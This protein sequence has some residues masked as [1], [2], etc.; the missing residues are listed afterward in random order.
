VTRTSILEGALE[1]FATA[2]FDGVSVRE[3]T[4]RLGVSHNL[5]HHYFGSKQ[6]LW[7]AVLDYALGEQIGEVAERVERAMA[8]DQDPFESLADAIRQVVA[9]FARLPALPRLLSFEAA[10]EGERLDHVYER[11]FIPLAEVARGLLA[12]IERAGG[13]RVDLRSF[14]LMLVT[15]CGSLF[16]HASV[17][18]RLGGPEPFSAEAVSLHAE[19]VVSVLLDGVR[20]AHGSDGVRP[21]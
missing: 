1:A 14:A 12:R 8:E 17:A 19:T 4:R 11:Y 13:A 21:Q 15:A 5:V 16:T 2:G 10:W 20:P 7:H 9:L 6:N 3:L 18:R